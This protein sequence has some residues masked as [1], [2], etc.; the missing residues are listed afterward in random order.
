MSVTQIL[1]AILLALLSYIAYWLRQRFMYWEVRGIAYEKPHYLLGNLDG[2]HTKRS[3]LEV[4]LTTYKKFKGT[5][6]FC[7]FFWFQRP[8]AFILDTKL[9]KA[10]LIKD[11]NNFVDRG[12]Y[13]NPE[14]DPLT[15]QLFLLDGHRWRT[16]RNKLSPTFTSGK[17]KYMF[18]TVLRVGEEFVRVVAA[19][20]E[21]DAV[22]EIRDYLARFTTDV[23]GTCAF[24]IEVNSLKNPS[25]EFRV[26]GKR[27]F[28]DLR[29]GRI[30]LAL[31]QSFPK[32]CQ[33]LHIKSTPDHI[34]D[35][36][37]GLVRENIEYREKNN[38]RRNDFFDML[39]DLKNNKMLKTEDGQM[40]T[41]ITVEE[42]T[43]QAFVFLVAGFETSST[44]MSFAL[45]ELAQHEDIQQRVRDEI[46]A[47]L[48]RHNGEFTYDC[49]REM[50]YLNQ[51]ISETLRLYTVLPVLNRECMEEYAVPGNPKYV[52]A[53]G[54]QV[55]IPAAA[56]HRDPELYPNPNSFDPD[57]FSP[58]KVA[59]RDGVEWL[60]F[61]EGPRNCIGMRFG[62]MQARIGLALLLKNFK[63]S[64]DGK[65]PIPMTYDKVNFL[66]QSEH[67]ICLYV[68]KI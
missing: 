36:Y 51:V 23:I 43:A 50:T 45:Y 33:R 15:G 17:M 38:I 42:I 49:M 63:F 7:G 68:E 24:G 1:L 40:M 29:Y 58:E 67:G 46:T 62:Q 3:F 34:T 59:H 18:P 65:T 25:D 53:K 26:M 19:D 28:T 55:V 35:F 4:W 66:V 37:M 20:I 12:F 56:Y 30:G 47:A 57:N 44:T 5:G 60:P 52:I 64:V 13:T 48:E 10:I 8:A 11:F 14:D 61:G 21:K 22:L 27:V 2:I 39:L 54:M 32:M 31:I 16:M 41:N 9:A 6:P